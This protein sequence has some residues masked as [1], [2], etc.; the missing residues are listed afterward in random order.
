MSTEELIH[1]AYLCAHDGTRTK[2]L[3]SL[4]LDRMT[5]NDPAKA[6]DLT[7]ADLAAKI[8]ERRPD[9]TATPRTDAAQ[10]MWAPNEGVSVSFARALE[11]ELSTAAARIAELERERDNY[12]EAVQD[13]RIALE[14]ALAEVA[15]LKEAFAWLEKHA[16]FMDCRKKKTKEQVLLWSS[17]LDKGTLF[18]A[19]TNA[20]TERPT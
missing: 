20:R 6:T 17:D 1:E 4:I 9:A 3:L 5:P 16:V 14:N 11:R 8:A 12:K 13:I 10:I 2:E 15:A 7:A 18:E 19:I